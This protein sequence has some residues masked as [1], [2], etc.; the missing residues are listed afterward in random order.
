MISPVGYFLLVSFIGGVIAGVLLHRWWLATEDGAD[1]ATEDG[2]AGG[3]VLDGVAG[4]TVDG[5]RPRRTKVRRKR[6][7]D[8]PPAATAGIAGDIPFDE[9]TSPGPLLTSGDRD[10]MVAWMQDTEDTLQTTG[11]INKAWSAKGMIHLKTWLDSH[12]KKP[13]EAVQVLERYREVLMEGL[14]HSAE[15]TGPILVKLRESSGGTPSDAEVK[16]K[17]AGLRGDTEA[18]LA[19]IRES[20]DSIPVVEQKEFRFT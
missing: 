1:G 12:H 11:S 17:L 20:C 2:N 8:S 16:D 10:R 3:D 13:V 9:I 7:D 19:R 4:G 5:I 14:I 15:L 6:G 18:R